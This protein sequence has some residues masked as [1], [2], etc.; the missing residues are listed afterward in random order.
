[1]ILYICQHDPFATAGGGGMASHA[2]LRAFADLSKGNI[3]LMCAETIKKQHSSLDSNILLH[4]V[5][6][7]PDRS[8]KDKILS[9]ISGHLNRYI[10]F[11]ENYLKLHHQV[12]K[13]IVFDHNSI[14]GPL[15]GIAKKYGIKTITIHHNYEREYYADNHSAIYRILFLHHV[16]SCERK[17]YS[18][19]DLNLFL[20]EQDRNTFKKVYGRSLGTCSVIGVFEFSDNKVTEIKDSTINK[21]IPQLVITGSLCTAQGV[22][23]IKYFFEEL[24]PRISKDVRIV[25]AGR[26]PTNDI[27]NLCETHKNIFL[28]PNP[29]NM[30]N[31]IQNGDIYICPTR[32]GG[33]LKLRVMDGLKLG[34]PV[35]THHCSARGYDMFEDSPF[36]KVFSDGNGFESGLNSLLSLYSSG[37]ISKKEVQAKYREYFT[38]KSGLQRL[39]KIVGSLL[40]E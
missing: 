35:I 14:A 19:S 31:I 21:R 23:G 7:V 30:E 26:K 22:D 8:G 18:L 10:S 13:L 12:Y 5:I 6:Y 4:N 1:M 20:T 37:R 16:I 36:F 32:V 15:V 27:V 2:Y 17:A 38:Y 25:I 3:D 39:S 40:I 34:I 28:V 24:Y 29:E 9:F 11:T 33:G